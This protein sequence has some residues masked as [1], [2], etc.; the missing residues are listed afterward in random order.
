MTAASYV[1]AVDW[2]DDDDFGD[3]GEDVT[4][5]VISEESVTVEYGRDQ[6]RSLAPT[7][8]GEARFVLNNE[9][10][11]YSPENASSP[12]F[13]NVLQARQVKLE[14]T[15]S[16]VTY[17]LFRGY[18]DEF[19]VYPEDTTSK[20]PVVCSDILAQF[21]QQKIFTGLH[22]GIRTGQAVHAV[23]DAL[24]WPT[25]ARDIDIGATTIRFWWEDDQDG[26]TALNRIVASEGLPALLTVDA[27][28]NVVFKDRHHRITDTA[29]LTSQATFSGTGTEPVHSGTMRYDH[30]LRDII[31]TITWTVSEYA[32]ASAESTVW[33]TSRVFS[34]EDGETVQIPAVMNPPARELVTPVLDTDY[35]LTLGAVT[36][37][38]SATSGPR[39]TVN[40]TA[41]GGPA[42]VNG[43]QVR[44]YS[45]EATSIQVGGENAASV[46]RYKRRSYPG[47]TPPWVGVNDA[48]ALIDSILGHRAER[49]P[50][51]EITLDNYGSTRLTQQLARD[52]SD[53]ITIVETE[54]QLDREFY[55]ERIRHAVTAGGMHHRS[56]FGCEAVPEIA[57]GNLF[58]F[59]LAGSGFD[60]GVFAGQ[61]LD[62]PD[63]VFRF[64]TTGLGFD[65]GVFAT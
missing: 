9:S 28:G 33:Q 50:W 46:A 42:V 39:V 20:V 11:D 34:L 21:R 7:R 47:E 3:T 60:D 16:A 36:V 44:G 45:L 41:T 15:H 5:R 1:I 6:A 13:G 48:M 31:N 30:G 43:M 53:R 23:L 4:A 27:S 63:T 65:D 38:L 8:P 55:I 37:T 18:L 61:G 2:N 19:D 26:L 24:D 29:S 58:T 52:L 49:L 17:G 32:Q 64:D 10:R 35:T 25:T 51:V 54:T 14:A 56:V 62:D 57:T 22:Q 40:V 12:L 59:D